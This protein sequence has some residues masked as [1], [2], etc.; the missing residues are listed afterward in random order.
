MASVFNGKTNST[1]K[2]FYDEQAQEILEALDF[3]EDVIITKEEKEKLVQIVKGLQ[4]LIKDGLLTVDDLRE[5]TR[6]GRPRRK[7]ADQPKD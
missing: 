1:H 7:P 3:T 2:N 4:E 6:P 5:S